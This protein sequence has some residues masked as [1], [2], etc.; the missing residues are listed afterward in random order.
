MRDLEKLQSEMRERVRRQP[1]AKAT[2]KLV[3]APS[4]KP[5]AAVPSQSLEVAKLRQR[6]SDLEVALSNLQAENERLRRQ[7]MISVER[8]K[9]GDETRREQQ[10]NYFKY[11]NARRW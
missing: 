1:K 5:A 7:K 11:S 6:I 4:S 9:S 2:Q 8:Q 10:H 3:A